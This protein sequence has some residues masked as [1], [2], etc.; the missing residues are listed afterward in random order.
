MPRRSDHTKEQLQ[1]LILDAAESLV[2]AGGI[3]R[4]SAR[5][6]ARSIG[7]QPGTIYLH[8]ANLDAVI[9][10]VNARTLS[11]LHEAI[12]SA[13]AGHDRPVTRLKRAGR[14]YAAFARDNPALWRLCFEHRLPDDVPGPAK[15]DAQI[16]A[17]VALI[18]QPLTGLDGF[19][20]ESLDTAAQAL[21]S[22]VHGICI[23]T[24]SHKLHLAG[25]QHPE[26]LIDSLITEYLKGLAT[27]AAGS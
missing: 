7:Y 14:A 2:R 1:R 17:L 9:L 23:L 26:V 6:I 22:G 19:S 18:R 20:G 25:R 4:L 8:F 11:R 16:E 12:E 5:A 21:W 13:I 10:G 15:M 24:L 3:E 27:S